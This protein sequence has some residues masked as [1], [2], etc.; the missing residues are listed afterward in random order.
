[1]LHIL[2]KLKTLGF[3]PYNI[4]DIGAHKGTWTL[5]A[6]KIFNESNYV[7]IDGIKY[8]EIDNL[9]KHKNIIYYN[10]ILADTEEEVIWY[11]KQ[12]SGDSLYKERTKIFS[13]CNEIKRHTKLL[14]NVVDLNK[15]DLVKL[16]VQGSEIPILKGGI[17]TI[18][19][20]S[21][22]IL[23]LPFMGKYNENVPNF[24]EHI[25]YMD[26]IGYILY[27]IIEIHKIENIIIQ[28]D[29]IFIKKKYYS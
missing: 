22:I 27:D 15:Y 11:E 2:Y 14:D 9:L 12:N 17:K 1:M 24:I 6:M 28:L 18:E 13:E 21:F 25:E 20:T 7:L 19:N 10:E 8:D 23:E 4:L 16:D 29:I 3:T 5:D 26:S